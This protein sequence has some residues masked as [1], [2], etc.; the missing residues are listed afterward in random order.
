MNPSWEIHQCLQRNARG[1]TAMIVMPGL[2][3]KQV[4]IDSPV[5]SFLREAAHD[6]PGKVRLYLLGETRLYLL[7]GGR[8]T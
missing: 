8:D 2:P 3:H 5:L 4:V 6:Q 7:K 1:K